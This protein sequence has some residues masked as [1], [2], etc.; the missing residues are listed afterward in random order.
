VSVLTVWP[1]TT[2]PLLVVL[3][4]PPVPF[5]EPPPLVLPVHMGST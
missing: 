3:A 2:V 1:T 5:P 4:V